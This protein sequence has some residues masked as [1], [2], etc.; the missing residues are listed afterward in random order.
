MAVIDRKLMS[1]RDDGDEFENGG[2]RRVRGLDRFSAA[3]G[4]TARSQGT[5]ALTRRIVIMKKLGF[6]N[7]GSAAGFTGYVAAFRQ[8]LKETGNVEGPNLKVTEAWADGDYKKLPKLAKPGPPF[9]AR[10][11]LAGL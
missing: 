5:A 1:G 9:G 10:A 7:S 3:G 11:A 2:A 6:L 4:D 8:G